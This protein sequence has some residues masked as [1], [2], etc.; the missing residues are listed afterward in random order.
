M[1]DQPS[2]YRAVGHRVKSLFRPQEDLPTISTNKVVPKKSAAVTLQPTKS[3][4]TEIQRLNDNDVPNAFCDDHGEMST[5]AELL[6]H[7][8]EWAASKTPLWDQAVSDFRA[9]HSDEYEEL[10]LPTTKTEYDELELSNREST[11][12]QSILNKELPDA[13]R[14]ERSSQHAYVRRLKSWLPALGA[15]KGLAMT[16]ARLDPYQMAPYIVAGAFFAIEVG[17]FFL[18]C[19]RTCRMLTELADS[20]SHHTCRTT[21]SLSGYSL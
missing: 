13:F 21:R 2:R 17:P 15:A 16:L 9:K 7:E 14:E 3:S 5:K 8:T 20:A 6:L 11:F 1:S 4:S 12:E 19:F 18:N 10:M